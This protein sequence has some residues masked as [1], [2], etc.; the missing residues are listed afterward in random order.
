MHYI[1]LL[2]SLDSPSPVL[3]LQHHQ[4]FLPCHSNQCTHFLDSLRNDLSGLPAVMKTI[5]SGLHSWTCPY[6]GLCS[7]NVLP[8]VQSLFRPLPSDFCFHNLADPPL[9][10][11]PHDSPL[12]NQEGTSVF[13]SFN[14]STAFSQLT[15][16]ISSSA[17]AH[18]CKTN[19]KNNEFDLGKD[20]KQQSSV[21]SR[22]I[23]G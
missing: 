17:V 3:Y 13:L 23:Q 18:H 22:N 16:C 9:D 2:Y 14:P 10:S 19:N 20:W 12:V 5:F 6:N 21:E 4:P 11:F 15:A 1:P 8:Q 7:L